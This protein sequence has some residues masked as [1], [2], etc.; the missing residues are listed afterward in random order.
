LNPAAFNRTLSESEPPIEVPPPLAA[1]WWLKKGDWQRAHEIVM[2]H[3]SRDAAWVHA[4]LHRIEGDEE[5]AGY[6]YR[7]AR[8][9]AASGAT[10]AEWDAIVGVLLA[11]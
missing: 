11:K 10:D 9:P 1:L 6:W 4:L 2:R 3:D 5:N 7:Q 8:R